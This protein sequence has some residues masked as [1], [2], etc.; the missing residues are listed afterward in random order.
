M[1]EENT[2]IDNGESENVAPPEID[3][4]EVSP[5]GDARDKK[6]N[7]ED[8]GAPNWR[9]A[10]AEPDMRKIAER[11]NTVGDAMK[12]ISDFRKRESTS[13]RV[14]GD[15]ASDGDKAK[16]RKA[17]GVPKSAEDYEFVMPENHEATDGDQAFQTVMADVFLKEAI[18]INQAKALNVAWNELQTQG[19]ATLNR[20]DK[21][22]ADKQ[23]TE[24]REEWRADYERNMVAVS[25]AAKHFLG[26]DFEE[27]KQIETKGG[28]FLLDN[29]VIMR[30]FAKAGREMR[31]GGLGPPMDTSERE[32]IQDQID[33]LRKQRYAAH[34]RQDSDTAARLD[35]QERNLLTKLHGTA[36]ASGPTTV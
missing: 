6:S 22:Y 24:L 3:E 21:D 11:F 35:T 34:D 13:I 33:A 15:D 26:S 4:S 23:D 28:Q 10:V 32:T 16:F 20:N 14:P 29:A 5:N 18:T 19:Q 31:E 9:D 8:T 25:R 17:M 1:A 7:G 12:A 2:A 30:M 36:P 27:A